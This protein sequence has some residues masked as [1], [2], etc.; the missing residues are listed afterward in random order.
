CRRPCRSHEPGMVQT[1]RLG[2]QGTAAQ[3]CLSELFVSFRQSD[4]PSNSTTS[5]SSRSVRDSGPVHLLCRR[6]NRDRIYNP[7]FGSSKPDLTFDALDGQRRII[8]PALGQA[9]VSLQTRADDFDDVV[10]HPADLEAFDDLG[11]TADVLLET[12]AN[13]PALLD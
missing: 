7:F 6:G 4:T 11:A 13:S 9:P 12:G 1:A 3:D 2:R 5:T 8:E 10:E